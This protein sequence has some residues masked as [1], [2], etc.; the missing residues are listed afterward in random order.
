MKGSR[1]F[2]LIGPALASLLLANA[3]P[4]A[5]LDTNSTVRAG[6][7]HF[8]RTISRPVLE[9]FLSRSIC[10]EGMLNA[11]G[12]LMDDIC[13]ITNCGAKY[14]ARALCLWG[15][16]NNFLANIERAKKEAPQVLA[17]DPEIVLEGCVFETVGPKVS[18]IAIPEWVLKDLGQP[19]A[20]RN[21]RYE[22]MIYP[23]GQR[24]R[25]GNAQVPDE[26]RMETQLW[27]YYQAASYIDVGCEGIHF[28]W[29]S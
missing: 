27:F 24:R 10:I 14:I 20:Q 18:Q 3:T 21:F 12:P 29:R 15:A 6:G 1:L 8:D 16:E 23:P 9:N 22:D 2:L 25:I 13:M 28:G 17:A 11:R 5:S 19:V 7:F 4:A 26:S